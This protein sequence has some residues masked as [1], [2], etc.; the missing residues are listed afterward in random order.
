MTE[1]A[2]PGQVERCCRE[3]IP[4]FDA[5]STAGPGDEFKGT[6]AVHV[7]R[8]VADYIQ[9]VDGHMAGK[10]YFMEPHEIAVA[11][12]VFGWI[13][14]DGTRRFREVYEQVARKNSKTTFGAALCNYTLHCDNEPGAQVIS[15]AADRDQA[16]LAFGIAK[17]M[18]RNEP[19]LATRS[20]IYQKSIVVGG[21]SY[22]AISADAHTKHGYNPHWVLDDELHAQPNRD[23]IDVLKTGMGARLQPM[24][25]HITTAGY[26]RE[27]IC[28][29]VYDYAVK[30][31][32]GIIADRAFLPVI[33]E[34]EADQDWMDE[35]LWPNANPNLGK[36]VSW[37]FL[38]AEFAKARESPAF[39]NTF[40]RLY[41]DQW[42]E[43]ESRWIS[44]DKWDRCDGKL[45]ELNG[46]T[47]Y[48]GLDLA[49]TT[50]T[51][52]LV[53][54]F[55][56]PD[57]SVDLL[58]FFWIP[59]DK[60]HERERRDRVPYIT[61]ANGGLIEMTPGNVTDYGYIRRRINELGKRFKIK[62]VA[63]DPWNATQL[64]TQL[65]E[66]DGFKMIDFRQGYVT[67][68]EPSKL[69]ER[70]I[71]AGDVRHGGNKVLRWQVSNVVVKQDPAGNIKPDKS[72]S[73]DRIDGVVAS[74]MALGRAMLETKRTSVYASRG[75]VTV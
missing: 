43:Q 6:L 18:T 73:S 46:R 3:E 39:E 67:M 23:L 21:S 4:G 51:S 72:K 9:H 74:I 33:F 56:N 75:L 49:A 28:Y 13:R 38:R 45:R 32:D 64:A 25:F 71:L 69:L 53:L 7:V 50:D 61:W 12:N 36:S 14:E 34:V 57:G 60:A 22:K 11:G 66:E 26:N 63:F 42:T 58:P 1:W 68:S 8:W 17:R 44:M 54:A 19:E 40:R 52:A 41:L 48:A 10:P 59:D 27:S 70:M 5:W 31:R 65:G 37:E 62:E 29:E 2:S 20:Q 47:C 55:P 16:S 15:C 35:T 30:V 24:M